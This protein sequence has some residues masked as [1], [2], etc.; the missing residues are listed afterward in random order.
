MTIHETSFTTVSKDVTH[1]VYEEFLFY[2]TGNEI[3]TENWQHILL[4]FTSVRIYYE[5]IGYTMKRESKKS[6]FKI[7]ILRAKENIYQ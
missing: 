4:T 7:K 5:K 2:V 1:K 3:G 6:I